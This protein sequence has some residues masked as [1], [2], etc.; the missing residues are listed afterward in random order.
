MINCID[1]NCVGLC[2]MNNDIITHKNGNSE[3][4]MLATDNIIVNI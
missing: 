2:G 3:V 1:F 4:I